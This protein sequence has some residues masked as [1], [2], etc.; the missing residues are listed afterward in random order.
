MPAAYAARRTALLY[1]RE[2]RWDLDNHKQSVRWDTYG[3]LLKQYRALKR[4]GAPV[5]VITEDQDFSGYPFLVV[6][7]YQ[8]VDEALVRRWKT[9][10]ENGGHLIITCRTGQKDR[11][12]QLW[13]GPWAAPILDLIGA[14]ISFYDTLPAPYVGKVT[15]DGD[16]TYDWASWGEVLVP[17]EGTV[18]LAHYAD[19]YYAGGVAA[20]THRLG[21]GVV[22]YI[23]VDSLDGNLEAALIRGVF[24]RAG[25]KVENFDDGFLVDWRDG[26]W[27]ATNFT[28]KTQTAPIPDGASVLIGARE[29]P[30][31]GVAAWQE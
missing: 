26:F 7:A 16:Q 18:A 30:T 14:K 10:A 19:Q 24:M 12:G 22:T 23:G 31:A 6:P 9:Y 1:G 27:V 21:R 13:E 17:G 8:L 3:H 29:V 28:E 2:A 11:R 4:L 5:D 25:V 20:V 15:K